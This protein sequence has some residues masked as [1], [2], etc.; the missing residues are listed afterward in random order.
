VFF[1]TSSINLSVFFIPHNLYGSPVWILIPYNLLEIRAPL[2]LVVRSTPLEIPNMRTMQPFF[3]Q[4]SLVTSTFT[5][6]KAVGHGAQ[7]YP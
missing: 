1:D 2:L 6:K 7:G 4:K 3:S 5:R